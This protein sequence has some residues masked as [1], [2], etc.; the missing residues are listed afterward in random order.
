MSSG[1]F[2]ATPPCSTGV[3]RHDTETGVCVSTLAGRCLDISDRTGWR[4]G[5]IDRPTPLAAVRTTN[6]V[7][8][9]DRF[10]RDSR[11]PPVV[12]SACRSA[13]RRRTAGTA[14][15]DPAQI[16]RSSNARAKSPR[17]SRAAS[18]LPSSQSRAPPARR[19][20]DSP[21]V[22]GGQRVQKVSQT[23]DVHV[24]DR[25]ITRNPGCPD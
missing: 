1:R 8:E 15:T 9:P 24:L 10:R 23:L 20:A 5:S 18:G 12:S 11:L 3:F 17:P 13:A 2:P 4:P 14:S 25:K 21:S 16:E 19:P 22:P 7:R 6:S